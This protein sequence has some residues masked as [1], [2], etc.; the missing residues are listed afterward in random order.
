M[1]L[2][3]C[4]WPMSQLPGMKAEDSE[5]L[6]NIGIRNTK[7]LLKH[8]KTPDAQQHLANQLKIGNIHIKKWVAL[9]QLAQ[10]PSVGW[11]YCGLI[12][13][14]GVISPLQLLKIH[15]GKLHSQIMR[16]QVATM[17]KQDLCPSLGVVQTWLRETRIIFQMR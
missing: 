14:A 8:T 3:P 2:E 7:E 12:L 6:E 15:P 1:A 9:A 13:H 16:L 4:Y 11:Q 10:I 5:K 17:Q